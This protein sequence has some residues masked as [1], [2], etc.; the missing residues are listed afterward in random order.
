L[1]GYTDLI[2]NREENLGKSIGNLV[3]E[4]RRK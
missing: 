3:E 4:R 1:Q 2:I